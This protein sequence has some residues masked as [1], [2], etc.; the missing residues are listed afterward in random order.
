[1]ESHSGTIGSGVT[2]PPGQV[3]LGALNPLTTI[4]SSQISDSISLNQ[5]AGGKDG[6]LP[7]LQ[8]LQWCF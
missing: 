1:M 4:S 6:A 8:L 5:L 2:L 7:Q 3:G